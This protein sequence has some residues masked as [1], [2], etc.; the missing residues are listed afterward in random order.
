MRLIPCVLLACGLPLIAHA[1]D[2]RAGAVLRAN[3]VAMGSMPETGSATYRYDYSGDGLTGEQTDT[4]DL[5]TGAYVEQQD[6]GCPAHR[7]WIRYANPWTRD[8]SGANTP[9]QGGDRMR[10]AVSA[11]YLNAN[12]WW[13]RDRGGAQIEYISRET[14][15]GTPADHLLVLPRGGARF[16][17]WFDARTHLLLQIAEP[18]MFFHTRTVFSDYRGDAGAMLAHAI[19]EDNGTGNAGYEHLT[20]REC[21]LRAAALAGYLCTSPNPSYGRHPRGRSDEHLGTVSPPQQSHLCA[22]AREWQRPLHLHSG[23]GWPYAP[24]AKG[25]RTDRAPR[26]GQRSGIRRRGEAVIDRLRPREHDFDRRRRTAR[27]GCLCHGRSTALT[28]KAFRSMAWWDSS[29][30][31]GS[32][33]R[34]TTGARCSRSHSLDM[35]HS[36]TPASRCR[37]SSTLI[38]PS[39]ADA[40]M[41]C[42]Q[43]ST[44]IP[45]HGRSS[46]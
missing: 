38:S 18:N 22:R 30:S 23:Y 29:S 34:S 7:R 36:A 40:S 42:R 17:A 20:L 32:S 16:D 11:A 27:S 21:E 9:E 24:V 44:S 26:D 31:A 2:E 10:V 39:F 35:P 14:L 3:Q 37:S 15:A 19:L 12:L 43:R 5:A 33:C 45:A 13:R 6:Y 25:D 28:S 41:R 1:A 46:T 8:V 4:V